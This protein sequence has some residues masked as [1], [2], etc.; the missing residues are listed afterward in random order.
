MVTV[1]QFADGKVMAEIPVGVEP[2]GMAVSHDDRITVATSEQTSMAHI[3]DNASLKVVANVLVDVRPR[4]A[5]FTNDGSA[6]WGIGRDRRDRL[7]VIDA[8]TYKPV[9]KFGF[10]IRCSP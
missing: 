2:E 6:V 3:I 1:L 5:E 8:K 4:V 9:K 10:E 7:S